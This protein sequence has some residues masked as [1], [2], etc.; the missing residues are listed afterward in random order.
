MEVSSP[1]T[2]DDDRG[3]ELEYYREQSVFSISIVH[4]E[5]TVVLTY[6]VVDD[7]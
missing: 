2:E 7:T 5:A 4:A 3:D 1:S 6:R